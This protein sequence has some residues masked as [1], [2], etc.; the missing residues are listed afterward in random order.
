MG[1][2]EVLRSFLDVALTSNTHTH[3]H[4]HTHTRKHARMFMQPCGYVGAR[5]TGR[6]HLVGTRD[7]AQGKR[8]NSGERSVLVY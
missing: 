5:G 1:G 4:T 8:E 7:G 3:I 2:V 6:Q